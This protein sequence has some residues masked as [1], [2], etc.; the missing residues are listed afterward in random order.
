MKIINKE[1]MSNTKKGLY[2]QSLQTAKK[3][4]QCY[5][6]LLWKQILQLFLVAFPV[7]LSTPFQMY[8][9]YSWFFQSAIWLPLLLRGKP[10]YYDL[11]I[12]I[13]QPLIQGHQKVCNDIESISLAW[14]RTTWGST[15]NHPIHLQGLSPLNP[16]P[17]RPKRL[18]PLHFC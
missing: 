11:I 5:I 1:L 10:N 2:I 18:C 16:C 8:L 15:K 12:A 3:D 4:L 6:K 7:F 14:P 9:L 13:C 17:K